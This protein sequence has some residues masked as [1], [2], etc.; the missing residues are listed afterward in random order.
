MTPQNERPVRLLI[1]P[2]ESRC[3]RCPPDRVCAWACAQ[4]AGIEDI[5]IGAVLEQSR[6]WA[7]ESAEPAVKATDQA[8]WDLFNG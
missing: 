7:L 6:S 2:S 8:L 4:G 1:R 5:L 3:Q